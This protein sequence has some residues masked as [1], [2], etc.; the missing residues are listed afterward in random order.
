VLTVEV[1]F[2]DVGERQAQDFAAEIIAGAHELANRPG[3]ECDVDVGVRRSPCGEGAGPEGAVVRSL[4]GAGERGEVPAAERP[5]R[6]PA[7]DEHAR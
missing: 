5:A 3:Q 6:R 7:A 4:T 1:L 2:H